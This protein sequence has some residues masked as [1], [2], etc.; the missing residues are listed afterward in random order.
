[1]KKRRLG[2]SAG[3]PSVTTIICIALLL[4]LQSANQP[5][6]RPAESDHRARLAKQI[7]SPLS[8]IIAPSASRQRTVLYALALFLH[9]IFSISSSQ[10][11]AQL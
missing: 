2:E 8:S 11:F 3:R 5:A 9:L 6:S 4:L 10:L 7:P 1:M